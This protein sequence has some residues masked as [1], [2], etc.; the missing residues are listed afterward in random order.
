MAKYMTEN[1]IAR[2]AEQVLR[3][4]GVEVNGQTISDP[5]LQVGKGTTFAGAWKGSE[6]TVPRIVIQGTGVEFLDDSHYGSFRLCNE[7]GVELAASL[8]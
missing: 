4:L 6:I 1:P 3:H 5:R 7:A 2:D 8:K